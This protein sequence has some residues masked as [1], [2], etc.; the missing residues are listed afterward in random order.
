MPETYNTVRI[1]TS[2][3]SNNSVILKQRVMSDDYSMDIDDIVSTRRKRLK[4]LIETRFGGEQVRMC[5]KIGITSGE[6][7]S[8]LRQRN[9]GEKKARAMEMQLHLPSG[10]MDGLTANPAIDPDAD[11]VINSF[12]RTYQH[13]TTEGK[14]F[15]KSAIQAAQ[16]LL[17]D[18]Q[19]DGKRKLSSDHK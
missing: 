5:E 2:K 6:L 18:E 15:L 9:F 19:N 13:A 16:G 17:S 10:W 8:L 12:V 11:E 14:T 3:I 4:Y 7:S 1:H